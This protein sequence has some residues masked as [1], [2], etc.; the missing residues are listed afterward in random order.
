MNFGSLQAVIAFSLL[1]ISG[2]LV[3]VYGN[4]FNNYDA[5]IKRE[6]VP[7]EDCDNKASF[8]KHRVL[9]IFNAIKTEAGIDPDPCDNQKDCI[10]MDNGN[11]SYWA[12]IHVDDNLPVLSGTML[13]QVVDENNEKTI[14]FKVPI[15]ITT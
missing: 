15:A 8:L 14:C 4:P 6:S 12:V 7:F 13:W 11:K 5:V 9:W 2:Y 1:Y 10:R 3:H